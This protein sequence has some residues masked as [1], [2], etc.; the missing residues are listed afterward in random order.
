MT[1]KQCD[2]C[3]KFYSYEQTQEFFEQ[4]GYKYYKVRKEV[5]PDNYS[6]E[7][8]LC[9]DCERELEKWMKRENKE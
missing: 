1:A 7:I 4:N 9:P 6:H 2:R 3:R 5:A 8:D